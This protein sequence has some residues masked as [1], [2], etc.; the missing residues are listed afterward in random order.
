MSNQ[1]SQRHLLILVS[2]EW[3]PACKRLHPKIL[4]RRNTGCAESSGRRKALEGTTTHP[5]FVCDV[6][7]N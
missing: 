1:A 7:M 3:L 6:E 5:E 4:R 2:A